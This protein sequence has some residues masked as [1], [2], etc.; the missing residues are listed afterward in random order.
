MIRMRMVRWEADKKLRDKH[1]LVYTNYSMNV[2]FAP[3]ILLCLGDEGVLSKFSIDFGEYR[4]LN[5][6]KVAAG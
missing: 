6:A 4:Q 3:W 2:P 1:R 5:L